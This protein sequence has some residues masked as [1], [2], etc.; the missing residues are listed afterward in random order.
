MLEYRLTPRFLDSRF[1]LNGTEK[2]I[3][4]F[5]KAIDRIDD[6]QKTC[7]RLL[8]VLLC[9]YFLPPCKDNNERYEY[10]REDCEALFKE[11]DSAMRE[12]L[13]AAKYIL[14]ALGLEFAHVGVPNCTKLRFSEEYEAENSTCI[15]WG[16][17]GR[18]RFLENS[19]YPKMKREKNPKFY[20]PCEMLKL[21]WQQTSP[22]GRTGQEF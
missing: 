17:F 8:K 3:I 4:E 10:C 20:S 2:V 13:G 15:H 14:K 9:E 6:D 12:M 11:C 21:N 7:K 16:L 22:H 19:I 18:Y 5:M 1:G